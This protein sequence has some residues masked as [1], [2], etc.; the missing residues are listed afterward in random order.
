[1]LHIP[2]FRGAALHEILQVEEITVK[3]MDNWKANPRGNALLQTSNGVQ[4]QDGCPTDASTTE[5]KSSRCGL[6]MV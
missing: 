6:K 2:G 1:M 5:I 3:E 4:I